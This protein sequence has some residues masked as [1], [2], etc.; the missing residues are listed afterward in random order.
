MSSAKSCHRPLTQ[1]ALQATV[2]RCA[3]RAGHFL[4]MMGFCRALANPFPPLSD[5]AST[6]PGLGFLSVWTT[7]SC[8]SS[9]TW[10]SSN[11]A[12]MGRRGGALC[13]YFVIRNGAGQ[14][15]VATWSTCPLGPLVDL[16]HFVHLPPTC[17]CLH[18]WTACALSSFISESG[19]VVVPTLSTS[20]AEI[21][22]ST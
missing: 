9:F 10:P 1:K 7:G 20:S 16:A 6:L 13:N 2:R 12:H 21:A 11:T 17:C 8:C 19:Q 4:K 3:V 15:V 22:W 14:V 5:S 18:A